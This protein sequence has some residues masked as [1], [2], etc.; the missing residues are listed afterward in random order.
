VFAESET[1][2]ARPAICALVFSFAVEPHAVFVRA[3]EVER[4]YSRTRRLLRR[5]A[6]AAAVCSRVGL[7]VAGSRAC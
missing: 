7:D 2:P 3:P 6:A 1:D 4:K 5:A